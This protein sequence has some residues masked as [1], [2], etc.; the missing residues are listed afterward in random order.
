LP[1]ERQ[2]QLL[3]RI[4]EYLRERGGRATA[5][6]VCSDVLGL[7]N[8]SDDAA[9]KILITG[10]AADSRVRIGPAGD[11]TLHEAAED[12]PL[13]SELRYAV[14]DI[15]TT[16]LAPPENRITEIAAVL[17]EQGKVVD[18]FDTL[19]NPRVPLSPYVVRMTGI[20]DEMVAEA[21]PFEELAGH[22]VELLGERVLVAHNS[23]FDI[24]FLNAELERTAGIK[25]TNRSLC[26][27]RMSRRLLRGLDGHGLDSLARYF[28]IEI[29]NRHR[30][31]G[32]AAA[33]AQIF[34][35]LCRLAEEKGWTRLSHLK[36]E[37]VKEN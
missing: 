35:R 15:E 25:L 31:L 29:G 37:A 21:P 36:G 5:A 33:T 20:T 6:A 8:C 22:L 3:D 10:L 11:L 19:V 7:F 27:V 24:N 28:A 16:G 18:D 23:P 34:L 13:L 12:D 9:S 17:V 14:I 2:S 30:A 1:F 26:T 4:V 32:D